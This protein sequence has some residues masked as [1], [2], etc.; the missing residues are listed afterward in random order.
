MRNFKSI[1]SSFNN[2]ND[3]LVGL[4]KEEYFNFDGPRDTG[5]Y[6]KLMFQVIT[7]KNAYFLLLFSQF[8]A[9]I[10]RL[11][12]EVIRKKRASPI[13]MERR[14]WDILDPDDKRIKNIAFLNRVALLTDKGGT[15][16][17]RVNQLYQIRNNIAHGKLQIESLDV[18]EIAK[19]IEQIAAELNE[20][21]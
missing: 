13:W 2:V 20:A 19:E 5:A 14:A 4:A 10:N 16:Y 7:N 11:C 9:E 15:V 8:E 3:H 1:V 17:N 6:E 18:A 21:S 12:Q